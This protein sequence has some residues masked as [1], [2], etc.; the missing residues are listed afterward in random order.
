[1]DKKEIK[2]QYL[3]KISLV[4]RYNKYYYYKNKQLVDDKNYYEIKV[5]I[6]S[7]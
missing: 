4:N 5:S 6:F 7:L 2:E 3:K 1:M